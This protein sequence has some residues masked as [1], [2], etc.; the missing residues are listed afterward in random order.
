MKKII[1]AS[2]FFLLATIAQAS[3]NPAHANGLPGSIVHNII[4]SQLPA[5]LLT[6]IKNQYQGYWITDLYEEGNVKRPSYY[7]TVENADQI[8]KMSSDD[9]ENWVVT[10]TTIKNN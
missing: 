5:G 4:S 8:I 9:S 3:T 1:F 10:S 7:I 2:V 6:E